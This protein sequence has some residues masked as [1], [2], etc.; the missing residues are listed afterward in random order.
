VQALNPRVNLSTETDAALLFSED[1]LAGFDLVVLT[2]VDAP[3]VVR[4][5]SLRDRQS[6]S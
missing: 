2:D 1:F 4:P 3:T 6:A 5:F